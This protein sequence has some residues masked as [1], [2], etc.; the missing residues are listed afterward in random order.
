MLLWLLLVV[1]LS[2]S[3]VFSLSLSL[4]LWLSLSL[5]LV[6]VVAVGLFF[7]ECCDWTASFGCF[8][9]LSVG[10]GTLGRGFEVLRGLDTDLDLAGPESE[11]LH[12]DRV[13]NHDGFT[14][15]SR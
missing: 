6:G 13:P 2:L 10:L 7:A 11:H 8:W 15:F 4:S 1:V 12:F 9:Y 3:L 14:N 5:S